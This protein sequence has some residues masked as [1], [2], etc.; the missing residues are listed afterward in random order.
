MVVRRDVDVEALG[1]VAAL[2]PD[3]SPLQLGS[4]GTF[5]DVGFTLIGRVRLAYDGGSWN[6]W[7]ALFRTLPTLWSTFVAISAIPAK[8]EVST[9]SFWF[10]RMIF[11]WAWTWRRSSSTPPEASSA[12]KVVAPNT[13]RTRVVD[14][15]AALFTK[16]TSSGRATNK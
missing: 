5:R 10:C 9:N 14:H 2:P 7:F 13:T 1:K 6:E 11:V 4:S 16:M 12:T 15:Q 3:L 8:R